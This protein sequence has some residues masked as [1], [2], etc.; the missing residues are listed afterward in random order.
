MGKKKKALLD[1]HRFGKVRRKWEAKFARFLE[2]NLDS[3]RQTVDSVAEKVE[4]VLVQPEEPT[5]TENA[6]SKV[7]EKPKP[8]RKRTS[9]AKPPSAKK[10]KGATTK[11]TTTP[12][13]KRRTTKTKPDA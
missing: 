12:T 13:R 10:P 7:E 3:I 4:E 2:A 6:T 11:K 8:T 9:R 1:L 5:G